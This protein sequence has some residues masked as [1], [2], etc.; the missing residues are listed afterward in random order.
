MKIF[1]F[2]SVPEKQDLNGCIFENPV[3][4]DSFSI[5]LLCFI[6]CI[7]LKQAQTQFSSK[8]LN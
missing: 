7:S 2:G 1:Y 8:G 3:F 4:V 6:L 5:F